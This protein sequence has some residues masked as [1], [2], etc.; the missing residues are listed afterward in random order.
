MRVVHAR[1]G[2][3]GRAGILGGLIFWLFAGV[4]HAALPTAQ[5]D[6]IV[7]KAYADD[8]PGCIAIVM[9]GGK[10]VHWAAA[11]RADIASG[12]R[13]DLD[14]RL[15]LASCSKAFTAMA[16]LILV[17]RGKLTLDTD[18]REHLPELDR[19]KYAHPIPLH[20]LLGMTAGLPDYEGLFDDLDTVTNE[21]VAKA[22]GRK[23]PKFAP[24]EEYE[25]SNT[26]YSMAALV[27]QR[28]SGKSF[29]RFV[30]DEIL[31]PAGMKDSF[32]MDRPGMDIPK[33]AT[34]YKHEDGEVVPS[35]DDTSCVGD[36]QLVT[37]A[38]DMVQWDRVL[39]ARAVT[40]AALMERAFTSGE[41]SDGEKTDYGFGWSTYRKKKYRWIEHAGS[42]D[43]TATF[44]RVYLEG[45]PTIVVL[46]N[47]EDSDPQ[48]LADT[49]DPLLFR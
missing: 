39:R 48:E 12:R 45:G 10:I 34:G 5:F 25:Y 26:A 2:R 7:R 28:V 31:T 43:G 18:V 30:K 33:R 32:V 3:G 11:G 23:K 24:G 17:D 38:R 47:D 6:R 1:R 41:T 13:F 44:V 14:T 27:V 42:W 4:A 49:L 37:S 35:L 15:D 19:A 16:A 21:R 46:S 40:S 9:Q 36:G 20:R 22:I 8:G 29:P